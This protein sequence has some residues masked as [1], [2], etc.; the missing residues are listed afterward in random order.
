MTAQPSKT[1]RAFLVAA[2]LAAPLAAGLPAGPAE[3]RSGN[4]GNSPTQRFMQK[5]KERTTGQRTEK[6][7]EES[8]ASWF[9][10]LFDPCAGGSDEASCSEESA[11]PD[12]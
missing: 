1:A 3:A 7:A 9:E 12:Q 5:A 6:P 2:L 11:E 4:N 8:G 10:E